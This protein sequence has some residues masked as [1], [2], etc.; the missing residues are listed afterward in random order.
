MIIYNKINYGSYQNNDG[1]YCFYSV[2]Y[3]NIKIIKVTTNTKYFLIGVLLGSGFFSWVRTM[4]EKLV[5]PY[6]VKHTGNLEMN[7]HYKCSCIIARTYTTPESNNTVGI[8]IFHRKGYWVLEAQIDTF[9]FGLNIVLSGV[10]LWYIRKKV[11]LPGNH[12][13]TRN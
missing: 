13:Q 8:V 10:L 2:V 6:W 4:I 5:F 7:T 9:K 3:N 11:E 1:H 12:I